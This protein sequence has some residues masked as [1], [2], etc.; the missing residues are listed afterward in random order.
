[1][2]TFP[3]V[4]TVVLVQPDLAVSDE[5]AYSLESSGHTV[6]IADS[7]TGGLA[8]IR[9]GGVDLLVVD[10]SEGGSVVE[11]LVGAL[12]RLPDAPPVIL[13]S[14]SPNAP[15]NS[16]RLGTAGFVPKPCTAFDIED[17][18][19]RL[20][21]RRFRLASQPLLSVIGEA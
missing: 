1:M 3:A 13:V 18:I 10:D 20:T 15:E 2:I 4:S 21:T 17:A 12:N 5:W 6:I 9:E 7:C 16:A 8:R 14:A 11:A 19:A